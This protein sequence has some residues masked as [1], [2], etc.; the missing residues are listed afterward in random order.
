MDRSRY[1]GSLTSG[2]YTDRGPS[3][4]LVLTYLRLNPRFIRVELVLLLLRALG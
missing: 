1:V 4:F 2:T 3:E